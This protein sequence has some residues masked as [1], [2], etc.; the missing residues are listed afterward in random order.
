MQYI[1]TE[2]EYNQLVNETKSIKEEYR[3]TIND[4]CQMVAD[5]MPIAG[6]HAKYDKNKTTEGKSPWG[7]IKSEEYSWYCDDCPVK[8]ICLEKNKRFS[9]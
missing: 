4:L 1:L 9:K 3:N 8:H 6:W 7:C 2:Q 5:N